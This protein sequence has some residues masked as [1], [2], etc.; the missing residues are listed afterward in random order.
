[1]LTAENPTPP[2]LLLLLLLAVKIIEPFDPIGLDI[3]GDVM[4]PLL[5]F[6]IRKLE[7]IR[8]EF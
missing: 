7:K 2:L 5:G 1:M 8:E 4:A 6:V 3:T